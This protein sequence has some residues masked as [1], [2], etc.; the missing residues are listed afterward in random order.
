MLHLPPPL[1]GFTSR[2]E[3]RIHPSCEE[4]GNGL[5]SFR[6]VSGIAGG[7]WNFETLVTGTARTWWIRRRSSLTRHQRLRYRKRGGWEERPRKEGWQEEGEDVRTK[8][9]WEGKEEGKKGGGHHK[10]KSSQSKAACLANCQP[11]GTSSGI[12]SNQIFSGGVPPASG[13][14]TLGTSTGCLVGSTCVLDVAGTQICVSS[15]QIRT[16]TTSAECPTGFCASVGICLPCSTLGTS[17]C[18]QGASQTCCAVGAQ[19]HPTLNIC[20]A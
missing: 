5:E 16:C 8:V 1:D 13:S 9:Q 11:A 20:L 6:P 14:C 2:Y 17:I 3:A 18:G 19:C 12:T 10:K 7:Y 15:D 4:A